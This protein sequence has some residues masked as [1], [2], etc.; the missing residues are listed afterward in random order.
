MRDIFFIA[1]LAFF[2]LVLASVGCGPPVLTDSSP[3]GTG[4]FDFHTFDIKTGK[5]IH[6]TGGGMDFSYFTVEECGVQR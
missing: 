2:L 6:V 5:C 3:V 1:G 4:V